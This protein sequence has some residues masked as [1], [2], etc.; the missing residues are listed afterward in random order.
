MPY[1]D[2]NTGLT[3]G[4]R[5]A[6]YASMEQARNTMAG[7][8]LGAQNLAAS[9]MFGAQQLV[10]D[11]GGMI[12]ENPLPNMHPF[13]AVRHGMYAHEMSITSDLLAMIGKGIPETTTAYEFQERSARDFGQR[14]S[15]E[16]AATGMYGAGFVGST[17]LGGGLLT[18]G[19][20]KGFGAGKALAA[21]RNMGKIKTGMMAAGGAVAGA[22]PGVAAFMAVDMA[23]DKIMQDV[24]DR[25]DVMNFLEASSFRYM[26]GSGPD[27][28][29]KFGSGFSR[30]AQKRIA[31]SIKEI[32][33]QDPRYDMQD[34]KGILEKGTELG[35]FSGT[36]DAQDFSNKFKDLTT[37]LKQVTKILHQSLNDGMETLKS[38]REI[39][40][41][42]PNAVSA[43][44]QQ[45]DILGTATG[46]TAAEVLSMGRQGA[47]MVR[48][49]G[50]S[51]A[52]GSSMMQQ[53][54]AMVGSAANTGA[55][56]A[57]MVAQGGGVEAIS[58]KVMAGHLRNLNTNFGRGAMLSVLGQ[59]G[60]V[61]MNRLHSLASGEMTLG[62]MYRQG[63]QN[64]ASPGDYVDAVINRDKNLRTVTAEYGGMGGAM[65]SMGM[66]ISQA[67]EL[68][69]FTGRSVRDTAKFLA[70]QKGE[71]EAD[72]ESR[73]AMLDNIDE[74][75]NK[76]MAAQEVAM[77]KAR[78]E[79][80]REM[81]NF[82]RIL[83]D[84]FDRLIN[85]LSTAV[86]RGIDYVNEGI[87]DVY[88]SAADTITETITGVKTT[89]AER[90]TD[91]ELVDLF[92]G[93]KIDV[94]ADPRRDRLETYN[95]SD[96]DMK[97]FE[98]KSEK[99]KE[100][101]KIFV[102]KMK[103]YEN[104]RTMGQGADAFSKTM[105]GESFDSLSRDEKMF[106]EKKAEQYAPEMA[107]KLKERRLE[108]R[109]DLRDDYA[110][111]L[112]ASKQDT[113]QVEEE[114]EN[115]RD[116]VANFAI[117]N[118]FDK[119]G[120]LIEDVY[121]NAD[122]DPKAA[123][124]LDDLVT[125]T[126][127]VRRIQ[128]NLK[129]A[130]EK[131]ESDQNPEL[132]KRLEEKLSDAKKV[133]DD[134]R[135]ELA[136]KVKDP[137]GVAQITEA[138][139]G[140]ATEPL[141]NLGLQLG[142]TRKRFQNLLQE[143]KAAQLEASLKDRFSMMKKDTQDRLI[144]KGAAEQREALDTLL[145]SI[146]ER[147]KLSAEDAEQLGEIAKLTGS[148]QLASISS[149]VLDVQMA[150]EKGQISDKDKLEKFMND[151]GMIPKAI[152]DDPKRK[153][154]LLDAFFEDNK[155]QAE[156]LIQFDVLNKQTDRAGGTRF[157]GG[158]T[159]ERIL[160][161]E[162]TTM[163]GLSEVQQR[164]AAVISQLTRLSLELKRNMGG[165]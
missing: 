24:E 36:R 26:Q 39:G 131:P 38:L 155:V 44:L 125:S 19:A 80:L 140:T 138:L 41:T 91:Q 100:L 107:E 16:I 104:F 165:Q 87:T 52:T 122:K 78:G 81:T 123:E 60:T 48:G 7:I 143:D 34:L 53:T 4:L 8:S 27:I 119:A 73:F 135:L 103:D 132:I 56:S 153:S 70:L 21:A 3:E 75:E 12:P 149:T 59:G 51:L 83:G 101:D 77:R 57:E 134:S 63:A 157:A 28:D 159:N 42:N 79:T 117:F 160:E 31:E 128:R 121:D 98:E 105:F 106:L 84:K 20:K 9:T 115:A 71:T 95:Y 93:G 72:F 46:R 150:M 164:T 97:K 10:S 6:T 120:D 33:L 43:T 102:D 92:V 67:K 129:R 108:A 65:V 109:K 99:Y 58:Q 22:V 17:M 96:R 127:D 11:L 152:L 14:I 113:E 110:E 74:Y 111:Q 18:K 136:K 85:P 94:K 5:R 156:K 61:D 116:K 142:D 162:A 45:A 50:I 68:A 147:K 158:R 2:E 47:E 154:Q 37:N 49:T 30:N 66:E 88:R 76:Q 62:Q 90:I 114:L 89:K 126:A 130:R 144:G 161:T 64:I 1:Q 25:Q 148:S 112:M 69:R 141:L 145:S 137:E 146:A 13:I 151:R 118:A 23:V 15:N 32:D 124:N 54:I 29:E 133:R 86:G 163:Q 40:I 35:M 82:G 139:E 55:L